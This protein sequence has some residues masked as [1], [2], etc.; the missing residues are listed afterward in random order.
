MTPADEHHDPGPR[1]DD[2]P[3]APS[4]GSTTS[5]GEKTFLGVTHGS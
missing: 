3:G 2:R 5:G 4:A 1:A